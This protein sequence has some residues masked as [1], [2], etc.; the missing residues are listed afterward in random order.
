[1]WSC[2]NIVK[3]HSVSMVMIHTA[4]RSS[5]SQS[6]QRKRQSAAKVAHQLRSRI[7]EK[8]AMLKQQAEEMRDKMLDEAGAGEPGA[9]E[10][11]VGVIGGE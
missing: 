9:G 5:P 4:F 1:M 10:Q 3:A 2:S 7:A 6:L 11:N 8:Q